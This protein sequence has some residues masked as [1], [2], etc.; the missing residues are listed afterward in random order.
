MAQGDDRSRGRTPG[1]RPTRGR[2]SAGS[3]QR[4]GG[5]RGQRRD[6]P[7]SAERPHRPRDDAR[8]DPGAHGPEGRDDGPPIDD[9]ASKDEL[10][11]TVLDEL[12]GLSA[13]MRKTVTG[14]LVMAGRLVDSDPELAYQHALAARKSAGR[15]GTVREVAGV[16]A[17]NAGKFQDA[18]RELRAA[19]RLTGN[20]EYLPLMADCE[21]GLGRPHRA[22]D[23]AADPAVKALEPA[24]RVEMLIVAAGARR[25]LGEHD[26]AAVSL[27]VPEL[28]APSQE[29]W[30]ARLR[31]AYAD[32]LLAAGRTDEAKRWFEQA[33]E[34]D[35]DGAT[36]AAERLGEFA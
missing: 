34:A 15:I 4:G 1:G 22:L 8:Q 9:D 11:P 31:Y 24:D 32:A 33:V 7:S 25:D 21:R 14:H 26:A 12:M 5:P 23:I 13:A 19:R 3:G 2:A 35:T 17:Y 20:A 18:L 16:A 30:V 28:R 10:E 36:D 6:R 27:Q 29:P